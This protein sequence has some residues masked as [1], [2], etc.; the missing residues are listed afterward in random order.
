MFTN[1]GRHV[2]SPFTLRELVEIIN[3]LL[4]SGMTKGTEGKVY[5]IFLSLFLADV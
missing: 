1:L 2:S 5:R 4:Q 3:D